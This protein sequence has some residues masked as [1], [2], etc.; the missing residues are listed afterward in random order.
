MK[1]SHALHFPHT[2]PD[3][4]TGLRVSKDNSELEG[5]MAVWIKR[6]P[7]TVSWGKRPQGNL[8]TKRGSG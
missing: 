5:V 6:H 8:P 2:A 4:E 3:A 1:S 7:K